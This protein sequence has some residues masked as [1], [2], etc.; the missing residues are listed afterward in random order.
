ME[1][2]TLLNIAARIDAR[3]QTEGWTGGHHSEFGI[4]LHKHSQALREVEESRESSR[5]P[6]QRLT[7]NQS[8]A[9]EF[10]GMTSEP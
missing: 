9:L 7:A 3:G 10:N 6:A 8:A 1:G 2:L 4:G 5:K